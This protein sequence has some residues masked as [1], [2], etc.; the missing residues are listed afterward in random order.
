MKA[1][2]L[3][4]LESWDGADRHNPT[5]IY[6]S[7]KSDADKWKATYDSYTE[8]TILIADSFNEIQE[9]EQQKVKTRALAK[10]TPEERKILGL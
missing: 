1:L 6:C 5:G 8:M 10:L 4:R 2:T 9:L 7:N 3:Y